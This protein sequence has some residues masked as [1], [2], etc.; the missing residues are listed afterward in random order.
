MSLLAQICNI[1]IFR[2]YALHFVETRRHWVMHWLSAF[3]CILGTASRV[4]HYWPL[5]LAFC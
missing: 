3:F 4:A 2:T 1:C 5:L